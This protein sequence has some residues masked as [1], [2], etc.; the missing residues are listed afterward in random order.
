MCNQLGVPNGPPNLAPVDDTWKRIKANMKEEAITLKLVVLI[1]RPHF[2]WANSYK[3]LLLKPFIPPCI[4]SIR[5]CLS[6]VLR[7][8]RPI[9]F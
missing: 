7:N 5:L 1:K 8:N 9:R 4:N 3:C 2:V 6:K